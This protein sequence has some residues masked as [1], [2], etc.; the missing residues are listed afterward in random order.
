M[1]S[2][3]K[4]PTRAE[5]DRM[6]MAKEGPCVPCIVWHRSGNAPAGFFPVFGCDYDHKKSGNIRRGHRYGFANCCWHHRG[7]VDEGMTHAEMRAWYGPSLMDGSR[8]FRE[9]Y[10]TDDE[11]IARQDKL[12]GWVD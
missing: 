9:A 10:G 6:E 8:L 11:L 5:R 3:S 2:K 12:I 7:L 1:R 4:P